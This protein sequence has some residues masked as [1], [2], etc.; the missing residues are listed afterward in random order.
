MIKAVIFD[1]S[2]VIV[3]RI[4]NIEKRLEPLL[5]MDGK[6][7]HLRFKN[8]EIEK[9][10]SCFKCKFIKSLVKYRYFN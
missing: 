5:N 7:I 9:R 3:T 1:L 4:S 2:G 6:E 8:K 10:S